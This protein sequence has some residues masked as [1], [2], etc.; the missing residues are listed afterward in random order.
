MCGLKK[1]N[2]SLLHESKF[3]LYVYTCLSITQD[4]MKTQDIN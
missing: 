2:Y 3:S 4:A 1:K